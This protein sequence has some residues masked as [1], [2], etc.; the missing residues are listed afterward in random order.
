MLVVMEE[1]RLKHIQAEHQLE[2][3]RSLHQEVSRLLSEREESNQVLLKVNQEL[4]DFS[5]TVSHDLKAPLRNM[6]GLAYLLEKSLQ[7]L[8]DESTFKKFE[9]LKDQISR[10]EKLLSGILSYAKS[11]KQQLEKTQVD[12]GI[13]LQE[14]I[15]SLVVPAGFTVEVQE[16]MPILKTEEIYLQQIFSNLIGNALKYHDH[17]NGNVKV[18]WQKTGNYT[19]FNVSDDGPGILPQHQEKIFKIFFSLQ[20]A[21]NED[22]SGLGLA[23]IKRIIE[24][25]G[26]RVWVESQG[27]GARFCF[28][29]PE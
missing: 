13:L 8:G 19:E 4:E 6:Q 10:M 28:T 29:W 22:S 23:I 16:D 24:E 26:G 2:E 21:A 18:G 17:P 7:R 15:N 3:I 5:Y 1:L 14:V 9:L 27:R 12:T 11:G 20:Q 25:K